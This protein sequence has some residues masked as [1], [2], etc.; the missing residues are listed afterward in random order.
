MSLWL[1]KG[2]NN[3]KIT[4]KKVFKATILALLLATGLQAAAQN[5]EAIVL[6]HVGYDT[7]VLNNMP[8]RKIQWHCDFS[9]MSFFLTNELPADASVWDFSDLTF[10]RD[11]SHPAANTVVDLGTLSIYAYNFP[12]FQIQRPKK[13]IFFRVGNENNRY[14]GVYTFDEA[15]GRVQRLEE[16]NN[17]TNL[18]NH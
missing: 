12:E 8:A 9:R 18:S 6:P 14:L 11:G 7:N 17:A 1:K 15:Y 2:N 16:L 4:M 5:C 3:T 13:T 10:L